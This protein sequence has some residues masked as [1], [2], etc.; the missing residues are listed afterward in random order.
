MLH[1]L[2]VFNTPG[3]HNGGYWIIISSK[4]PLL[5]QRLFKK[6]NFEVL[7]AELLL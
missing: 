5:L 1:A 7:K 4:K 6:G 2:M 3:Q